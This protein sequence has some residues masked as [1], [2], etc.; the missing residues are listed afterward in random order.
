[1]LTTT[2]CYIEEIN[3]EL[4]TMKKNRPVYYTACDKNCDICGV[5]LCCHHEG[6]ACLGSKKR[7]LFYDDHGGDAFSLEKGDGSEKLQILQYFIVKNIKKIT[8][9]NGKLVI[10]YNDNTKKTAERKDQQLQKCYQFI[11]ALPSQSL[12]FSEL[13]EDNVN[14]HASTPDKNNNGTYIFLTIG[15]FILGGI[16]VY[17]FARKEKSK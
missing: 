6:Q 7:L 9:D 16:F 15:V 17:F 11:Q 14:N 2:I 13:Q 10:K 1:M 12:S 3:Y 8:L 4:S 5:K